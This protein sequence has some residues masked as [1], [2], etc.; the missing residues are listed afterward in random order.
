MLPSIG[1]CF[2]T[3]ADTITGPSSKS[4]ISATEVIGLVI[5]AMLKIAP[6]VIGASASLSRNPTAS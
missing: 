2:P 4:C 6:L 1:R 5:E 3:R